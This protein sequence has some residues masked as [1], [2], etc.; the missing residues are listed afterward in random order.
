MWKLAVPG[1]DAPSTRFA[2]CCRRRWDSMRTGASFAGPSGFEA[3]TKER[4][5]TALK[6][7]PNLLRCFSSA[8]L[9][10]A[11]ISAVATFVSSALFPYFARMHATLR[12]VKTD[13]VEGAASTIAIDSPKSSWAHG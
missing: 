2:A 9:S 12:G 6:V 4:C 5:T 11:V 1:L 8:D 7:L 3:S 13:R 10:D